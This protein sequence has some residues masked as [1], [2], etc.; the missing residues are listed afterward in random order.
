MGGPRGVRMAADAVLEPVAGGCASAKLPSA[1][2]QR[3]AVT[4]NH[5][6]FI[7]MQVLQS[8]P[9]CPE[10]LVGQLQAVA[11]LWGEVREQWG[12]PRCAAKPLASLPQPS[13]EVSCTQPEWTLRHNKPTANAANI[14][15]VATCKPR[16]AADCTVLYPSFRFQASGL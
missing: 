4:P 11:E 7:A 15:E 8:R 9:L 2:H 6:Y 5:S 12:W 10:D 16:A 14:N 3:S 13:A 1:E